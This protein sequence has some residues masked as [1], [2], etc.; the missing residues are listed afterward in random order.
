MLGVGLSDHAL[1][2][3][4]SARRAATI[5]RMAALDLAVELRPLASL[6]TI[7]EPWRALGA[8]ALEP[9]IFY[10]PAFALAAAPVLGG[11]VQ[12][13]L[14]WAQTSPRELL[15][16]FPVRIEN[17][18][19]GLPLPILCGWTHPFAPFG[20]PLVHRDLAEQAIAAW[21]DF[22]AADP[23]LPGLL[24]MPYLPEDGPFAAVMDAVLARR[25]S[26]SASYDR[27]R[28]ALL[29]PAGERGDYLVRSIS[30]K[31]RGELARLWRRLEDSAPVAV[32]CAMG[33]SLPAALEDFL[34]IEASG[35]KGRAHS[36][37]ANNDG[38]LRFVG[39]AVSALAAQGQVLIYRLLHGG[40]AIAAI[41]ALRSGP[42]GWCWK[43]AYDEDYARYS[44]GTQL[45]AQV[46][47]DLLRDATLIRTDSLA[48]ANHPL[49][50]HVWRERLTIADRLIGLKPDALVPFSVASRLESIRRLGIGAA[51]AVRDQL[52]GR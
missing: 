23:A 49:I 51:R 6:T 11:N 47:L 37:A 52:R 22:L 38:I 3:I 14:V 13:G 44:P 9:N 17:R 1:A 29:A 4:A 20:P 40:R 33:A 42:G 15:A 28:R 16:L 12:A 30:T 50:D 25:D 19:Y 32:D 46:T 43:I 45:L 7:T 48:T 36:A 39:E 34:R 26:A 5:E 31:R 27:H 18:R 41:I 35:W 21:F 2:A 8:R 24:L 10:E